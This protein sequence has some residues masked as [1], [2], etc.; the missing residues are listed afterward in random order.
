MTIAGLD[1]PS[2]FF[3][4][5]LAGYTDAPFRRI[6]HEW[7]SAAAV[8]E[9]VSAEGLA[10]NSANTEDLL[11]RYPGEE[12]LIVQLFAPDADPVGRCLERL[13]RHSP[14][15]IDINCGCPVNKVV[16]T[17]AG[18]ALMKTPEK[19]GQMV[20]F[21]VRESGVPVSVKFRL[22]WDREH[23]NWRDFA[24]IAFDNGASM[25]TMHARTRSQMYAGSA[26]WSAIKA[27]KDE[28]RNEAVAIF[29]S[30]DIFSA[31]DAIRVMQ[32]TG[33][34]G[35]M[36]ARG[37]I[38]NPFIF[39]SAQLLQKGEDWSPSLAERKETMLR[40]L[41]YMTEVYGEEVACRDMRKHAVHYV[42]GLSGAGKAKALF[43]EARTRA[44]YGRALEV[45]G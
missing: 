36:M 10:R 17:G 41:D 4:A 16:K 19:M 43:N 9:M 38:G 21:L 18:S 29:A 33:C 45:L 26:D 32:E 30:G 37:A 40:H 23:M 44:D 2:P 20:S 35:V 15:M 1:F 25:L 22:G 34:D 5:P 3:L 42:K 27:L 8:T 24:H 31:A 12:R 7:G 39:H 13:M 6:A 14:A 11:R 28:F